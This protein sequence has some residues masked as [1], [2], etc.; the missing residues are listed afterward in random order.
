MKEVRYFYQSA[1][2][3]ANQLVG[4][5]AE[6][7]IKVLRLQEGDTILVTD[8]K[9]TLTEAVISTKSNKALSFVPQTVAKAKKAWNGE[10]CLAVAPTKNG[11]RI[12]WLVEKATE[13]GVDR[14]VF[15]D[16]QFSERRKINLQRLERVAIA[17]MKQSH[18]SFLPKLEE[19]TSFKSFIKNYA[20][21]QKA[22]SPIPWYGY[23]AHCYDEIPEMEQP[24]AK[25]FLGKLLAE[26][27]HGANSIV[28]I[29]P[30]GDFSVNEVRDAITNG[31]IPISLGTQRLR[32]ETAA[33]FAVFQMQNVQYMLK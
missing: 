15:L 8:G 10:I 13:I 5:E 28:L 29:G 4:D 32:T 19:M 9:G 11:D 20:A 18:K 33:L 26:Q 17:A 31:L 12:E 2:T 30:E 24:V 7:A 6:H 14:I 22:S 16:C 3:P 21:L 27:P 1:E 25:P 23:I